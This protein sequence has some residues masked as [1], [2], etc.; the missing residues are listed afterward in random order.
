M[1]H[2]LCSLGQRI[3]PWSLK[4]YFVLSEL[5]RPSSLLIHPA[6]LRFHQ[7]SVHIDLPPEGDLYFQ[8]G[9]MDNE[10]FWL[11]P[12]TSPVE[13][14]L[15]FMPNSTATVSTVSE[16]RQRKPFC[17]SLEEPQVDVEE[18]LLCPAPSMADIL[19]TFS[20]LR[21]AA[22]SQYRSFLDH[23]CND[24]PTPIAML[25]FWLNNTR[26][27]QARTQWQTAQLTL[28]AVRDTY[29]HIASAALPH[30]LS[31]MALRSLAVLGW[32]EMLVGMDE[33]GLRTVHAAEILEGGPLSSFAM[34][35]MIHIIRRRLQQDAELNARVQVHDL[36]LFQILRF[37]PINWQR[38]SIDQT[39]TPLR[40]LAS[41]IRRQDTPLR[42]V[43]LPWH[44]QRRW[45]V[46]MLDVPARQI[47]YGDPLGR[48]PHIE[49]TGA[50]ARWL[51]QEN[52]GRWTLG[53]PLECE[54]D[55]D[56]ISCGFIVLD[57]IRSN[58]FGQS[59][60]TNIGTFTLCVASCLDLVREHVRIF[61]S[62]HG[63]YEYS[64]THRSCF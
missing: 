31:N 11:H 16:L 19:A 20:D 59:F 55:L 21:E 42:A 22:E 32:D 47:R 37:F 35:G 8:T 56:G 63:V 39:F 62:I 9:L 36:L 46:F 13:S 25:S 2:R 44:V 41:D 1:H 24:R 14:L 18:L 61:G 5:F 52:L 51:T 7:M 49:D 50:I 53:R 30:T 4:G 57:A 54:G 33:V 3:A 58:I 27:I 15:L 38:Y 60:G 40:F 6:A 43:F 26:A 17:L 48:E 10:D 45:A 28:Q 34:D 12:P 23:R 29:S 64:Q